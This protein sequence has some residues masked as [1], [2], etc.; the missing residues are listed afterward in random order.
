MEKEQVWLPLQTV[1][2]KELTVAAYL[3]EQG[4][5]HYIPMTYELRDTGHEGECT[6]ILVPAIHNL[7][8]IHCPYDANWCRQFASEAPLPVYFLKKE[9]NGNDYC[10]VSERDM[11]NFMHA[12]NPDIHGTRFIDSEKLRGKRSVPVRV[13]RRG[14]LRCDRQVPPLRRPP[15]HRHRNAP[16]HR[17]AQSELH[18]V[19]NHRRY[20]MK[21]KCHR[22]ATICP[23]IQ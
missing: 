10:T 18:L 12:T 8:F 14:P 9:R 6:H 5:E 19:R 16:K 3:K 11:Q 1:Y 15:L 17:P 13:V 21:E 2:N 7:I 4:I 20:R 23:P 22:K